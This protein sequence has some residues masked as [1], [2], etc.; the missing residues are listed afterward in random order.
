MHCGTLRPV[1]LAVPTLCSPAV[2]SFWLF[3]PYANG[4]GALHAWRTALMPMAL[5]LNML[6]DPVCGRVAP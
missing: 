6:F 2:V 5:R 4:V 1:R 3:S